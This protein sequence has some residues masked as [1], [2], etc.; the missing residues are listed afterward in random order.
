MFRT[1]ALDVHVHVYSLGTPEICRNLTFRDRL[2]TNAEDRKRYEDAR[3]RLAGQL[4]PDIN[5]YAEAKTDVIESI[6]AAAIANGQES[7]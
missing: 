3:R 5:A 2:R 6:M 4:W 7:R 1:S